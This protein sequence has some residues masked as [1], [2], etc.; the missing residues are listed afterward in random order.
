[1]TP[2]MPS[3]NLNSV[4]APQLPSQAFANIAPNVANGGFNPGG[5]S[6]LQGYMGALNGILNKPG[7]PGQS[8]MGGAP[9]PPPQMQ[10]AGVHPGQAGGMSPASMQSMLQVYQSLQPSGQLAAQMQAAGVGNGQGQV[11]GLLSRFQ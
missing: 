6:Q 9:P 5:A 8:P 10:G 1:M 11:P 3:E 7:G 4:L 2:F